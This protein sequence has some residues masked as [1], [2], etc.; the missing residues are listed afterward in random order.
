MPNP[1]SRAVKKMYK[2]LEDEVGQSIN[3]GETR[4]V[5]P[6]KRE[7]TK[8]DLERIVATPR[9]NSRS[10]SNLHPRDICHKVYDYMQDSKQIL[11]TN[12]KSPI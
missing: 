9:K 4:E 1:P 8:R 11:I 5:K 12:Y 10:S 7:P 6:P 3:I 2:Y